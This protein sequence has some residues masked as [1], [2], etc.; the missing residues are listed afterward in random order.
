MGAKE[1][2]SSLHQLEKEKLGMAVVAARRQKQTETWGHMS[3]CPSMQ[4]A[5][6][7]VFLN[8]SGGL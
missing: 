2:G 5:T 8:S 3:R 6:L 7:G 4:K 1:K